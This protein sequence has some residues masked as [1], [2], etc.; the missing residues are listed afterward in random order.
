MSDRNIYHVYVYVIC[1][2]CLY[3][4]MLSFALKLTYLLRLYSYTT[5]ASYEIHP[6]KYIIKS[7]T[8]QPNSTYSAGPA[9]AVLMDVDDTTCRCPNCGDLVR[10]LVLS[11]D[12]RTSALI[13]LADIIINKKSSN[14]HS[15]KVSKLS[16]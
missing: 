16:R 1:D 4:F 7:S 6:Q 3:T 15:L 8:S 13:A 12:E 5:T 2:A 10:S 11:D 14:R 9:P